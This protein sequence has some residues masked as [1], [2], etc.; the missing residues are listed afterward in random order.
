MASA[1]ICQG[2]RLGSHG[3]APAACCAAMGANAGGSALNAVC[4]A[5]RFAAMSGGQAAEFQRSLSDGGIQ[6]GSGHRSGLS[7]EHRNVCVFFGIVADRG[8]GAT[9]RREQSGSP[10]L[11]RI[12]GDPASGAYHGGARCGCCSAPIAIRWKRNG[13]GGESASNER[14]C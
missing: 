9:L 3:G 6:F 14:H 13:G 4:P 2:V 1:H 11:Q 12:G 10:T 5:V 7:V 8:R